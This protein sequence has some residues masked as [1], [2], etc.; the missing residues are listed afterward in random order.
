VDDFALWLKDERASR[1]I[2]GKYLSK[3]I[4]KSHSYIHS[5]ENGLVKE[6]PDEV[7]QNILKAL[8]YGDGDDFIKRLCS[9][10]TVEFKRQQ[11]L[12]EIKNYIQKFSTKELEGLV[13]II[14]RCPDLLWTLGSIMTESEKSDSIYENIN[15]YALF[16]KDL[17][18]KVS[19]R[20]NHHFNKLDNQISS[21]QFHD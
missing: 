21:D 20:T 6:I 16:L 18:R 19:N 8:G 17:N 2:S 11:Y 5:L 13:D 1:R 3:T 4:G 10:V 12:D 9:K 15:S 14:K 7:K